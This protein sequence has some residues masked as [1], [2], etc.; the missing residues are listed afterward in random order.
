MTVSKTYYCKC[1]VFAFGFE[2]RITCITILRL[3]NRSINEALPSP[4]CWPRFN[5]MLLQLMSLT[6][7][8]VS[9]SVG[10]SRLWWT[11]VVFM[12]PGVN[13]ACARALSCCNTRLVRTSH[14]TWPPNRP[15]LSSVDYRLLRVIK[16]CVYQKQQG[17]SNI[18]DELWLLTEWHFINTMT[19][20]ISQGRVETPI[21]RD[22]QLCCSSVAHLL[23]YLY[24]KNY[25]NILRFDK[26][27]SKIKGCN[28]FCSTL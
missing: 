16:E 6:C 9:V 20:Y 2:A 17:T 15:D 25:Q 8:C 19:Y 26:I 18:V 11:G 24:A 4:G 12:Q 10:I 1:S 23:Q 27:I 22:E 14:Q 13:H 28:F 7:F 3:I 21:R 5:Q